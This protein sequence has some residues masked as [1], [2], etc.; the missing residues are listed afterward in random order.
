MLLAHYRHAGGVWHFD[1]LTGVVGPQAPV[2]RES[3]DWG[4]LWRQRGKWFA[5]RRD[6]E[7]LVFQH[8]TQQWRL[9]SD[10]EFSVTRGFLRQFTICEAGQAR[11]TFKYWFTGAFHANIDPTY[12]SIDEEADDFFLYVSEMWAHW[13]DKDMSTFLQA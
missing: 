3:A 4:F 2:A 6:Q 10:H 9:R 13:K 1:E 12:D 11:F 7:S 5:I 8:G